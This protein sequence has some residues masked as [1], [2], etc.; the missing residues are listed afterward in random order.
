MS[1]CRGRNLTLAEVTIDP[2]TFI[3]TLVPGRRLLQPLST[4]DD[5]VFRN[6]FETP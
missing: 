4:S 2:E 5:V 3:R 1:G 6:G